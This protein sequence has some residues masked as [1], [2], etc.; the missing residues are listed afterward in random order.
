V[1]QIKFT[2]KNN[3]EVTIEGKTLGEAVMTML[4]HIQ[5]YQYEPYTRVNLETEEVYLLYSDE[6]TETVKFEL[7]E[8]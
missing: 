4:D 6:F 1:K 5:N 7:K 8:Y 2:D 3:D